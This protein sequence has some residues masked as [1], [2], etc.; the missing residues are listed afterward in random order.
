MFTHTVDLAKAIFCDWSKPSGQ[1]GRGMPGQYVWMIWKLT[2]SRL[3]Q[4]TD[5]HSG[6]SRVFCFLAAFRGV[7]KLSDY[8]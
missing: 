2:D 5:E 6:T 3:C 4:E 8:R 7:S 1:V